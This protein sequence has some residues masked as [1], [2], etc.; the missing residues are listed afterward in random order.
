MPAESNAGRRGAVYCGSTSTAKL[1]LACSRIAATA[2]TASRTA[3]I[4]RGAVRAS[5]SRAARGRAPGGGRAARGRARAR[6]PPTI[7]LA[8]RL[9]RVELRARL[10]RRAHHPDQVAV[11]RVAEQ[12]AARAARPRG[13]RR[14]RGAAAKRERLGRRVERLHDHAPAALARARCGRRAA[15]PA[16]TCAP[17]RGSPGSAAWRRRRAPRRASR[18][19]SRGPWR[20]SACPRA[21]P[22]GASSKRRSTVGHAGGRRH[23]GVEPEHRQRRHQ[24]LELALELLGARAVAGDR[25]RAAVGARPAAP[26]RGGRSG[27]R[28]P[29]RARGAARA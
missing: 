20:P 8:D 18:P 1:A 10:G 29:R 6:R 16:R 7:A 11:R 21:R 14:R 9:R 5:G 13:S 15:P 12:L 23:V 17:R 25:H 24:L 26:A 22:R 2:S 4:A 19:G 28:T 27:G 3:A